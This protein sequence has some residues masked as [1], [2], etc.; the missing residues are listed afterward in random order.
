M[1]K[2]ILNVSSYPSLALPVPGQTTILDASQTIDPDN[3][4]LNGG[5]LVKTLVLS[6]EPYLLAGMKPSMP[7]SLSLQRIMF[8]DNPAYISAHEQNSFQIGQS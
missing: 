4:P 5:V 3:V 6:L 2:R 8:K 7:V 1:R